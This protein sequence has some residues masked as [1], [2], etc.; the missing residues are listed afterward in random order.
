[1]RMRE[2]CKGRISLL[3]PESPLP[4][5]KTTQPHITSA[6]AMQLE[7]HITTYERFLPPKSNLNLIKALG[8]TTC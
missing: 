5:P 6:R 8:L 7:L 3:T 1:M 2:H 4:S